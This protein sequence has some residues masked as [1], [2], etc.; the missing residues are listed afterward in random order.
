MVERLSR[1]KYFSY[2]TNGPLHDGD[3][4]DGVHRAL[5]ARTMP[6]KACREEVLEVDAG[7]DDER[8]GEDPLQACSAL[9]VGERVVRQQ[10]GPA[11]EEFSFG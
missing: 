11:V 8:R 9:V 5:G 2:I 4:A 3:V 1:I 10:K 6:F 7:A